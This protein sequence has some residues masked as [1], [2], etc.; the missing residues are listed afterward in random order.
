M[1]KTVRSTS[2]DIK[3]IFNGIEYTMDVSFEWEKESGGWTEPITPAHC[4]DLKIERITGAR[5]VEP[6]HSGLDD[7]SIAAMTVV[8]NAPVDRS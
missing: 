1:K 3:V 2:N 8:E 5:I 4:E 7:L 6:D